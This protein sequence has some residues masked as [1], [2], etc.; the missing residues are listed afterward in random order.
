[1]K[2]AVIKRYGSP[3]VVKVLEVSKPTPAADEVLIR[4]RA[5]TVNRTDCGELRAHDVT[6]KL[7]RGVLYL[8]AVI[9]SVFGYL[10]FLRL[11]GELWLW[12]VTATSTV[13]L[14]SAS[15]RTVAAS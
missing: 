4:V 14:P 2:A 3:D 9:G 1:M 10:A 15:M 11:P 6:F 8:G 5:A 7:A 13:T 12:L